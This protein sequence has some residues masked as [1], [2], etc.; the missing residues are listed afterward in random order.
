VFG[1]WHDRLFI[2]IAINPFYAIVEAA[3]PLK[4]LIVNYRLD[5][6]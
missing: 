1:F 5:A 2:A 6:F 3:K 4:S